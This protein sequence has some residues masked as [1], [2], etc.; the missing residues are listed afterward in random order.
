MPRAEFNRSFDYTFASRA[1]VNFPEGWAGSVKQEVYDAA[2][3]AGA[4]VGEKPAAKRKAATTSAAPARRGRRPA[5][6][7]PA[8][9]AAPLTDAREAEGTLPTGGE[10]K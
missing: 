7:T 9:P 1:M 6:A 8:A 3:A 2:K 5:S 10:T 4:L